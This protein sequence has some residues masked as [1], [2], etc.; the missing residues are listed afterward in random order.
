MHP[1]RTVLLLLPVALAGWLAGG[2]A[3]A[4][5]APGAQSDASY[6]ASFTANQV[7][8][9]DATGGGGGCY[10]PQGPDFTRNGPVH[11]DSGGAPLPGAP[12]REGPA[13]HPGPG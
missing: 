2:S 5:A 3:P 10:P 12:T 6:A 4:G 1:R 9:V 11:G 8:N 7:T 13:A